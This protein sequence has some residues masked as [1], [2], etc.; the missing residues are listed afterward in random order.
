MVY[1]VLGEYESSEN[2]EVAWIVGVAR[3]EAG[4][5]RLAREDA[6][7]NHAERRCLLPGDEYIG[8]WDEKRSADWEVYYTVE[9]HAVRS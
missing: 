9:D 2:G 4:A 8:P 1:V 5:L 6:K 3:T 7:T